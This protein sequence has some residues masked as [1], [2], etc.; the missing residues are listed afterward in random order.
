MPMTTPTYASTAAN[1][2]SAFPLDYKRYKS[3]LFPTG[4]T[5]PFIVDIPKPP[6][7]SDDPPL[8]GLSY[9]HWLTGSATCSPVNHTC[10]E[11]KQVRNGSIDEHILVIM[12]DQD[13]TPN[14]PGVLPRNQCIESFLNG[15]TWEGNV[16]AVKQV[17]NQ[18]ADVLPE[19][20]DELATAVQFFFRI[21]Q[22]KAQSAV[23]NRHLYG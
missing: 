5:T 21:R 14:H 2:N 19:Q 18:I 9:M 6:N 10:I 8:Y 4:G 20:V 23:I 12:A 3:L 15:G 17:G 13:H 1:L 7:S 11:I 22:A 16:L